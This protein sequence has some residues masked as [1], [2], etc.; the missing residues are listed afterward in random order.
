M[1][2]LIVRYWLLVLLCVA[3]TVISSSPIVTTAEQEKEMMTTSQE[4]NLLPNRVKRS[5]IFNKMLIN[6]FR[7]KSESTVEDTSRPYYYPYP[8][9][10]KFPTWFYGKLG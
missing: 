4:S 8:S 9:L 2:R 5:M 10:P 6:L 1:A 3:V 7:G